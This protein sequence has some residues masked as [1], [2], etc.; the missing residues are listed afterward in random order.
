M[1]LEMLIFF[2]FRNPFKQSL[3]HSILFTDTASPIYSKVSLT[4]RHKHIYRVFHKKAHPV[5]KADLKTRNG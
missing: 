2:F 4:T 5:F 3:S 1:Y